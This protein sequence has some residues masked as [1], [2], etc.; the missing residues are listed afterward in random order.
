MNKTFNY[1]ECTW[2]RV[3]IASTGRKEKKQHTFTHG[4]DH[5]DIRQINTAQK[6][7]AFESE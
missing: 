5:N 6:P 7:K 2:K 3:G 4:K 1:E